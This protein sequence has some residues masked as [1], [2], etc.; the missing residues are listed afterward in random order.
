MPNVRA[1][2]GTMGTTRFPISLS[3]MSWVSIWTKTMVVETSRSTPSK[4]RS[5]R[6]GVE[7]AT[8]SL[9]ARRLGTLRIFA[10]E[11]LA[12]VG[13]GLDDVF[14]VLAV[15]RLV[16]ALDEEAGVVRLDQRVPVAPPDHLDDVPAGAA[17]G[18]LQLLDNLAV[19][20]H[21]AV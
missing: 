6:P 18:G 14:L 21:R 11:V 12:D 9:R 2:S 4:K 20:A 15:E 10:E 8:G 19:A 17:E 3:F 5:Q 16:H 7:T 1:S 13:A